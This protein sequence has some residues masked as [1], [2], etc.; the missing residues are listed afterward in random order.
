MRVQVFRASMAESLN[1]VK[2]SAG[3]VFRCQERACIIQCGLQ[4]MEARYRTTDV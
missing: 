4:A 2:P 3:Y 1:E